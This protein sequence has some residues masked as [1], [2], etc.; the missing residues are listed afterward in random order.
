MLVGEALNLL[1]PQMGMSFNQSALHALGLE[2]VFKGE[3]A[4]YGLREWEREVLG[5]GEV[6]KWMIIAWARYWMNG[7]LGVKF[8]GALARFSWVWTKWL[9]WGVWWRV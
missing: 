2:R 1:R 4:G 5:W 9:V 7:L 8:W 3:D 6:K